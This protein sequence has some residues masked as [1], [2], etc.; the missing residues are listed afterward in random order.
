MYPKSK[1]DPTGSM[2][3]LDHKYRIPQLDTSR[4]QQAEC[5]TEESQ[6]VCSVLDR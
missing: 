5:A 1:V 6:T 3:V 4:L 2:P